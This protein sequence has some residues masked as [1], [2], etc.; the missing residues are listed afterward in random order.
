MYAGDGSPFAVIYWYTYDMNGNQVYFVGTGV[1]DDTGVTVDFVSTSGM[2]FGEFDPTT[3][4]RTP[5]GTA[6][7]E[8][9][10]SDNAVFSYT[11]TEASINDLGHSAI[12]ELPLTRLFAIPVN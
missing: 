9:S 6:R 12:E 3:V 5:A 11:P 1:P 10:D 8:F 7:F 4:V 2:I